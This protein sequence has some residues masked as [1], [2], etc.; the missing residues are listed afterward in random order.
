MGTVFGYC[1]V[2]TAQQD[3]ALQLDS[4]LNR[5]VSPDD[6]V[7]ET[8]SGAKDRP[9]LQALSKRLRTGDS[10]M[11]WRL[12]R[13]AR[14]VPELYR[15]V[16]ELEDKGVHLVS[17]RDSIDTSVA[18]GRLMLGLLAVLA[19]FERDLLIERTRA[20][21]EVAR[22]KGKRFGRPPKLTPT[23]IDLVKRAHADPNATVTE[24]AEAL[25]IS[26]ASYY[27]AL[28]MAEAR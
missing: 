5:G 28:K 21:Q 26:R 1:R 12:D 27:S 24:T 15:F 3:H 20:G 17:V 22:R 9:L 10:L 8:A 7:I 14:S 25:G 13:I 2:S 19:A 6:I 23:I 16:Q 4:L 11:V 18:T